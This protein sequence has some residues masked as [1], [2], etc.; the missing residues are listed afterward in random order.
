MAKKKVYAVKKGRTTGLFDSWDACSKAVTG[1]PGAVFKGFETEEEARLFLD[2]G[3]EAIRPEERERA[4]KDAAEKN[5][6]TAQGNSGNDVL[7][8]YVDGSFDPVIGKYSFG[9]I[10]LTPEG[11]TIQ[12]SGNGTEPESLLIR[13]VAG[14]MLGAMHAVQWALQNGYKALEIRY[15]YEGIERWAAGDWKAKNPLTRKYADFMQGKQQLLKITYQKVKAHS[16]DRYNEEA[17]KLAKA[18][19]TGEDGILEVKM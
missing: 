10:L 11:E 15:D 7:I 14:E 2:G 18:A 3:Q 17:D 13:N 6:V 5:T 1:Y 9:C 16:G 4:E 8:A 19:L 12:K